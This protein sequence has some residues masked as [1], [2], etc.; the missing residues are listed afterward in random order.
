MGKIPYGEG[1]GSSAANIQLKLI[2]LSN[3]NKSIA[4][5]NAAAMAP[6]LQADIRRKQQ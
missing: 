2:P 3:Y 4:Y 5:G 1:S 6:G